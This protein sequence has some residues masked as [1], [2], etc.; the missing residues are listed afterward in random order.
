MDGPATR[1]GMPRPRAT[2]DPAPLMGAV[3][4][5]TEVDQKAASPRTGVPNAEITLGGSCGLPGSRHVP[6]G[7]PEYSLGVAGGIS[8]G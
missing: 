5:P 6:P 3:P 8:P 2:E 4:R 7:A 1:D